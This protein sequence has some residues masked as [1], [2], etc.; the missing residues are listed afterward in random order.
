M[1]LSKK[2]VS[3]LVLSAS[4]FSVVGVGSASAAQPDTTL[5]IQESV[6]PGHADPGGGSSWYFKST[7]TFGDR[8][9]MKLYYHYN[10]RG[11]QDGVK[12]MYFDKYGNFKYE[13]VTT[14]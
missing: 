3:S 12:K 13:K 5:P 9:Y 6:N 11:E 14:W 1:K 4:L 8:S 10:Y 2:L 7:E